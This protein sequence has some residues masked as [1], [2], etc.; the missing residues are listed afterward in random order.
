MRPIALSAAIACA[1]LA[2]R[3]SAAFS[4]EAA[5]RDGCHE[6]ITS[7]LVRVL[8]RDG[9]APPLPMTRDERAM[10]DDL[11][12]S[13]GDDLRDLAAVTLLVGVR[14]NDLRGRGPHE[15]DT[16]ALLHGNNAVQREHC[17]R[18]SAHDGE[19]GTREALAACRA[20]IRE[21]FVA[22]LEGLDSDGVPSPTKRSDLLITLAVRGQVTVP[23]P[24]FYLRMGEAL[25]ALQD[26]FSHSFRSADGREVTVILNW[27]EYVAKELDESRDGPPHMTALDRCDDSDALRK[28]RRLWATDASIDLVRLAL[29]RALD[30]QAKRERVDTVLDKWLGYKAGCTGENSW[31][32]APELALRDEGCGCTSARGGDLSRGALFLGALVALLLLRRARLLPLLAL[33][34]PTAARADE[35]EPAF[36]P[37]PEPKKEEPRPLG[38]PFENFG[39]HAGAGASFRS[40]GYAASVGARYRLTDMWLVGLDAE[41]NPWGSPVQEIRMGAFN[42]YATGIRR[43]SIRSDTYALRTTIHAGTSTM[44]FDLYGAPRG[45]TGV[46][47]G[48]SVIGVEIRLARTVTMIVDPADFAAPIP[49]LR[50]LFGYPQYR[51]TVAFQF[52]A[53]G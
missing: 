20:F 41:W 27:V 11:P 50:G 3:P 29:D 6:R 4:Y 51:F 47:L 1:S 36:K 35:K 38:G 26:S 22:A 8:R 45:T 39:V 12:F 52:G 21:K 40:F 18:G 37:C 31:C 43:W 23:L 16:L 19:Q 5:S 48:V 49:Q 7:D 17:L 44:L 9:L 14:D 34:V 30:R 10:A 33:L 15:L 28:N 42:A 53:A 32:N 46:Y 25:H 2:A 13:Y 24:T